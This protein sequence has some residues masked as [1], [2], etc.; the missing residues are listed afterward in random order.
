MAR[1][2]TLAQDDC[3]ATALGAWLELLGEKV[4]GEQRIVWK[5]NAAGGEGATLAY[6]SLVKKVEAAAKMGDGSIALN[7]V[8]ALVDSIKPGEMSAASEGAGWSHLIAMLILT[9]PEIKWVFGVV[10]GDVVDAEQHAV[11]PAEQHSLA[12]LLTHARRDPLLDPTGLRDWVRRITNGGLKKDQITLPTRLHKAAAIDEE[13][14]FAYF[15]AYT[16]YR[17]GFRCDAVTSWAL[18]KELFDGDHTP[19]GYYVLLEDMSLKFPDKPRDVELADFEKRAGHCSKL[20]YSPT[21]SAESSRHRILITTGQTGVGDDYLEDSKRYLAK[22]TNGEHPGLRKP[23]GGMLDLWREAGLT[24]DLDGKGQAGNAPGF[25]ALPKTEGTREKR[26]HGSPGKLMLIAEIL[27]RR[28]EVFRSSACTVKDFIK[29]ATLATEA[30]ELLGGRTPTLTLTALAL[31]HEYEARA[32]CAFVG[33]GYHFDVNAREEEIDRDVE[34]IANWFEESARR[35]AQCDALVVILNRI[36]AVF[37]QAGQFEEEQDA[38]VALRRAHRALMLH[39]APHPGSWLVNASLMYA[40]WLLASFERF[41]SAIAGWLLG[42]TAVW[43]M[44]YDN[45]GWRMAVFKTFGQF[46]GGNPAD[47]SIEWPLL[48]FSCFVV[49]LGVFHIGVF[50]S[51]LYSVI[52]RR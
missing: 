2:L 44:S 47:A 46:F 5:D 14:S 9:F 50:I 10:V 42:I 27:L 35:R 16:A 19:H 25:E 30:V 21:S 8:V 29:G 13:K 37:R 28:A 24:E 3:T 34:I 38:L 17:F 23:V 39:Q 41:V 1:Y 49:V 45:T 48:A 12:S 52:S 32:E 36:A 43:W 51:Y 22:K 6:E 26:G 11:F 31:K 40:E 4:A 20:A 18:M 33:A 7:D 15:H